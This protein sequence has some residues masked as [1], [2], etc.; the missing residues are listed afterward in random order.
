MALEYAKVLQAQNISFEIIGNRPEKLNE[1]K[2]I[3]PNVKTYE[4]G[5]ELY[6]QNYKPL[7][8]VII[9]SSLETGYQAA[10]AFII[11]GAKNIL[12]E[13]PAGLCQKEIDDLKTLASNGNVRL[14]VAYNRRF[15]QSLKYARNLIE[16]D[17]GISSIHFEFTEWI[18]T[19]DQD[20]FLPHVLDKFLIGNSSHV[21][22]TVFHL[23][24]RPKEISTIIK[25]N[26]IKWHTSGS[27]FC[28][29]GI[30]IN[31]IPFSYHSN[32]ESA[33]RWSIEILTLKHRIYLKPMEKLS[34]QKLGSIAI[35]EM[36][37]PYDIDINFKPGLY[38]QTEAFLK[39]ID[40]NL[41]CTIEE[42]QANFEFYEKIAGYKS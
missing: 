19:I 8:N 10:K 37:K 30:T 1:F 15:Y 38:L 3:Y 40:S 26:N 24:G 12:T 35:E 6:L 36:D 13:K 7:D 22:D 21:I 16:Q 39:R 5:Y 41:I 17:G 11:N 27:I 14:L 28:G 2:K 9:A 32:W 33:G 34:I 42:H 18:H 23:A 20:K 25:G 31:D 29:S 4:G